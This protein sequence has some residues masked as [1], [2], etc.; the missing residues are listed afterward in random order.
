MSLVASRFYAWTKPIKFF[1]VIVR[2]RNNWVQRIDDWLLPNANL[3]HV[4]VLDLP[5]IVGE[6]TRGRFSDEELAAIG[7]LL[8]AAKRVKHLAATWNIWAHLERECGA[9]AVESLYLMWDRAMF[10]DPP[11]L[12]HL[13]HPSV[14]RDLTIHAPYTLTHSWFRSPGENYFPRTGHCANLA[15]VAYATGFLPDIV[16]A[17]MEGSMFICVPSKVVTAKEEDEE[18]E[19]RK[20]KFLNFSTAY[21]GSLE[22]L[23]EE[24]VAKMEGRSNILLH[25]PPRVA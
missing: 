6:E 21:V 16:T 3:I 12:Y 5:N 11:E 19:Q 20:E 13:Q 24:W 22:E 14:L 2:P 4:L 15:Y 18:I 10:V 1:T 9:I 23:L 8:R 7:R 25:P 17:G